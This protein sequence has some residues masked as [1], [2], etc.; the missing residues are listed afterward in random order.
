MNLCSIDTINIPISDYDSVNIVA[1]TDVAICDGDLTTLTSTTSNGESPFSYNW[2]NGAGTNTSATVQPSATTNYAISVTDACSVIVSDSVL[3]TVN[4]RPTISLSATNQTICYGFSTTITVSGA[5]TYVWSPSAGLSATTGSVVTANPTSTSTYTVIGTD[6]NGC[7]DTST[8]V[9]TVIPSPTVSVSPGSAPICVG[10]SV[11][12]T[13]SGAIIYSWSPATG[14]SAT[15]GAN[16]IANPIVT[17]TYKVVGNSANATSGSAFRLQLKQK[18]QIAVTAATDF[19]IVGN[20]YANLEIATNGTDCI[21][22]GVSCRSISTA[23]YYGWVQSK[24]IVGILCEGTD[25]IG[26]KIVLSTGTSGAVTS[27]SNVEET[28]QSIDQVLG[29]VVIA[30]D[31][32]GHGAY[33]I[34]VD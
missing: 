6:V 7:K 13:A 33:Y 28:S 27:A 2:S 4:P 30:G 22:A 31:D 5:S 24:G 26:E 11:S 1:S 23:A 16:V 34:N 3:V 32:T 21:V 20:K 8:I 25:V 17:T 15:T 19:I 14:L 29:S 12:L 10:S 18:L 9:I